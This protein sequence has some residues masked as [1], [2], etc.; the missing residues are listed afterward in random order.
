MKKCGGVRIFLLVWKFMLENV[1]VLRIRKHTH[2]VSLILRRF[3]VFLL[4]IFHFF[5]HFSIFYFLLANHNDN[6]EHKLCKKIGFLFVFLLLFNKK[7]HQDKDLETL[8]LNQSW[9]ILCSGNTKHK[10]NISNT[11]KRVES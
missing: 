11:K 9:K 8:F 5:F 6:I 7:V 3:A 1:Y 4:F 2:F 10:N